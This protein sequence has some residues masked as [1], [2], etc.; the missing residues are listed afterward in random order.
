MAREQT[1]AAESVVRG[2]EWIVAV[3]TVARANGEEEI[4]VASGLKRDIIEELFGDQLNGS[5]RPVGTTKQTAWSLEKYV[6]SGALLL[7]ERPA[8][9]TAEDTLPALCDL[10]QASGT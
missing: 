6:D 10:D 8:K 3:E 4:R 7:Q 2:A 5:V 1:L 9:A